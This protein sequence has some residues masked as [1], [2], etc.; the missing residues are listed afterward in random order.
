[1]I[2]T[3]LMFYYL[4]T[5][6]TK[7]QDEQ[8]YFFNAVQDAAQEMRRRDAL[9]SER[10]GEAEEREEIL[11]TLKNIESTLYLHTD[12]PFSSGILKQPTERS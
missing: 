4:I 5:H 8:T 11:N 6:E 9:F 10:T 7:Q 2:L 3:F 12:S 1:M